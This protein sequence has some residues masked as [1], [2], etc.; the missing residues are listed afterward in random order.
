VKDAERIKHVG[1]IIRSNHEKHGDLAVVVSAF[2]G[3]TDL[4]L[5]MCDL[6]VNGD[7]KYREKLDAFKKRHMEIMHQLFS[8][9]LFI[10]TLKDFEEGFEGLKDLLHG[11]QLVQE[12]SLR[13]KD[14][15]LSY[16]E[17]NSA[18]I[19]SA[20]L[21]QLNSDV[22]YLDA[23]HVIKTDSTFGSAVVD[24]EK[25]DQAIQDYFSKSKSNL[26]IVTGF[27]ASNDEGLTTTL[28]RGGSDFTASI[29]GAAMNVEHVEIW[30]DVDG[31]LTSDPRKVSNAFTIPSLTY[32]EAMEMSHFGA[33]VIYPPTIQP[34]LSKN[35]PFYIKNT[36]NPDFIGTYVSETEDQSTLNIKGVSSISDIVLINLQG[37]GLVGVPGIASRLFGALAR[38]K[39]NI[40]MITQG[41]SEHSISF[42]IEPVHARQAKAAVEDE[43]KYELNAK[44]IDQ[45]TPE[46][47]LSTIAV[48]GENM[49]N[50]PGISGQLFQSLGKNGINVVAIAQGSSELNISLVVSKKD[51]SKALNVI[52]DGFFLSETKTVHVFMV[53]V[54]LIGGTLIKQ[55]KDHEAELAKSL[56][57]NIKLVGL[58]NS[59]KMVFNSN[60]L[61]LDNWEHSL[62]ISNEASELD[63]Y[64][65]TMV[66]MNLRNSIFIDNTA[67]KDLP[68]Y[69][70][71]ILNESISISTP[72]KVATSSSYDQYKNLKNIAKKRNI[73]FLY[74]TNVG[75]G[76]PLLTT[77]NQL[78]LSGDRVLGLEAI[79][80]GSI[81]FIF[82]NFV[83]GRKFSELVLEAQK[84]GYTEPDPREDLGGFD[85]RRKITILARECGHPTEPEDVEIENILPASCMKADSVE[86][87]FEALKKEDDYFD[88]MLEESTARKEKLRYVAVL[89][90]SK[91]SIKLMSVGQSHPFYGLEGSDNMVVIQSDRYSDRPLIIRGPGAGAEVTA[92]G[93]FA[94]IINIASKF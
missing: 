86:A 77:I 17:R 69:Y 32:A 33:K 22:L 29:L 59:K 2:G 24:F 67:N 44:L 39:V 31:V 9:E 76:L 60:G 38:A 4:L 64:V 75:A 82:N 57:I 88:K 63:A 20:Y 70:E 35:I 45:I 93:V 68:S 80:S 94:E 73:S 65:E 83:P 1:G 21:K 14:H 18:F 43:F 74:E 53:G 50:V 81:S 48:I 10:E 16:G 30:T 47:N 71:K 55:I 6:A 3:I 51:E 54:G 79:L 90:G 72:N 78:I 28:G 62:K 46:E 37:T 15:V 87:F 40:I 11:I 85:V 41:S 89:E 34:L 61:D 13:T 66:A 12:A 52:H 42:A 25:T 23:R 36:F 58:A 8:S 49:K 5:E 56:S 84:A 19:L 7:V 91:T 27:I 26:H 92:A